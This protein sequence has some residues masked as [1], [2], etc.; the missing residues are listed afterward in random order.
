MLKRF[1]GIP[2]NNEIAKADF[3]TKFTWTQ[4]RKPMVKQLFFIN[5][6]NGVSNNYIYTTSMKNNIGNF[7][8]NGDQYK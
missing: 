7:C 5:P 1:L 2:E 3:L 8:T 6:S 4:S